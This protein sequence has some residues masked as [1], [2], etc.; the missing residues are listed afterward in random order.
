MTRHIG[1]GNVSIY[2]VRSYYGKP[3]KVAE[4]VK[5]LNSDEAKLLAS[6]IE[7]ETGVKY[8]NTYTTIL[9]FGDMDTQHLGHDRPDKTSKIKND[10]NLKRSQS[11]RKTREMDRTTI[12]Q[13]V[14]CLEITKS[15]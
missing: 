1:E 15:K 6:H 11:H 4:Y 12:E 7:K 9:G 13:H 5:W 8:V 2:W 14:S 10:A 3:G